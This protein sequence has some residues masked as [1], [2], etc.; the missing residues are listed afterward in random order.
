MSRNWNVASHYV[1]RVF[2][3]VEI[4][5]SETKYCNLPLKHNSHVLR[6]DI[7]PPANTWVRRSR[8]SIIS[9]PS[10]RHDVRRSNFTISPL[11]PQAIAVVQWGYQCNKIELTAARNRILVPRKFSAS[12][13]NVENNRVLHNDSRQQ[14]LSKNTADDCFVFVNWQAFQMGNKFKHTRCL[15]ELPM[16]PLCFKV[17]RYRCWPY[18]GC[19]E[20]SIWRRKTAI[21]SRLHL[22]FLFFTFHVSWK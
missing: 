9:C 6:I 18:N 21:D 1:A 17:F 13:L 2:I 11:M 7:R 19:R 22:L 14:A 15:V 3:S 4:K 5:S 12:K 8:H 10:W 16:Q 20:F